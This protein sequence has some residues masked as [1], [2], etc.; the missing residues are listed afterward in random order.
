[1][2]RL[3]S[4]TTITYNNLLCDLHFHTVPPEYFL[5]VLV[6]LVAARVYGISCLMSLLEN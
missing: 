3:N 5:Q 1:M 2:L 6:Y 4:L